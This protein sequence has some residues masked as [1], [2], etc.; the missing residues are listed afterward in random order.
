MRFE[1]AGIFTVI[2]CWTLA[3][4]TCTNYFILA[5][6]LSRVLHTTGIVPQYL[7]DLI[8]FIIILYQSTPLGVSLNISRVFLL[9]ILL[10]PTVL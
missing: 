6:R 7:R 1:L 4:S 9:R 10:P 3:L 8:G 2:V 5:Q